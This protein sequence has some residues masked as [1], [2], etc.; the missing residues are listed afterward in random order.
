MGTTTQ[1]TVA[2]TPG[3]P[4]DNDVTR[5]VLSAAYELLADKGLRGL[6]M[7][8]LAERSGVPKSSIYRRWSTLHEVA[9]DAVDAAL[10]P[11]S[12][13]ASADPLSDL[14]AIVRLAHQL[15]VTSPLGA[16]VAQLA[17]E[18][19]GSSEAAEAYRRRVIS[20]LRDAAVDAVR[21]AAEAGR[22]G[23]PD[24]AT[25]VDILI[26]TLLYRLHYLGQTPSLEEVFDLADIVA[27][28]RLP[29]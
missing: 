22:W 28:R 10:G 6:R 29:R 25:S 19:T 4:R 27:G 26:G 13:P 1:G 21:R 14:A 11:R 7:D 24:P 12:V 18:F 23:G 16:T 3:R 9:A 5:R 15:F 20:P 8:E 17:Q 2:G